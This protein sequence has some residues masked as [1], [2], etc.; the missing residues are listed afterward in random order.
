MGHI[1][2]ICISSQKG[3]VKERINSAELRERHGI[4]GDAHAGDWHRQVSLLPAE[5]IARVR[6]LMPELADGAFA[7]NLVTAGL[8]RGGINIGARVSLAAGVVLE[9]TQIGK[10]C[11]HG[12]AIKQIT[13]DCIM[14]REGIFCKVVSGGQIEVGCEAN[15]STAVRA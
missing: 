13:G 7:E 14:P 5:S 6:D 15:I 10:E 3:T 2:A 11:H 1:A 4:V 12:C 8:I 9:V